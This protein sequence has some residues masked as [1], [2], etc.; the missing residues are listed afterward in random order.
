M[1][2]LSLPIYLGLCVCIGILALL[3]YF[4][5]LFVDDV[6]SQDYELN[7]KMHSVA[8][9]LYSY[10]QKNGIYPDSLKSVISTDELC[11]KKIFTRCTT[12]RYKVSHDKQT[13]K[14]AMKSFSWP[15]L[16]YDPDFTLP[17][18]DGKKLTQDDYKRLQEK[19]GTTCTFCMAS[20][21][22]TEKKYQYQII[23]RKDS[24]IFPNPEE[25][26]VIE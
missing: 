2:K 19:Y 15:I 26:P 11:I 21:E 25:W 5:L 1:K 20:E 8:Q 17:P 16:F 7:Q 9:D 4:L 12:L 24:K 18:L 3:M 22:N 23:Y 14:M 10:K 6:E 13:F